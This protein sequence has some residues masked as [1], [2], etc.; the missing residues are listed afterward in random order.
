MIK[1]FN[2]QI[3]E[4]LWA[5]GMLPTEDIPDL[6]AD[7]IA[8]GIESE[9]LM[10]L[11]GCSPQEGQE[12]ARLFDNCLKQKGGGMSKMHALKLCAKMVSQQILESKVTAQD[13]AKEIWRAT[14]KARIDGFH[15]LDAFIYAASEMEDR[16]LERN[17]FEKAII[18][19]ARRWCNLAI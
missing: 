11:A 15:E 4:A 3:A 16:P 19:E 13:G 14:L 9:D 8:Q 10:K 17:L 7:A 12:I 18:E 6:A 1:P 2:L 5:L